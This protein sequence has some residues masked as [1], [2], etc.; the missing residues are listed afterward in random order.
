MFVSNLYL[1]C[2][3]YWLHIVY[4]YDQPSLLF[5]IHVWCAVSDSTSSIDKSYVLNKPCGRV[6]W[7]GDISLM[8]SV[9]ESLCTSWVPMSTQTFGSRI[10][11]SKLCKIIIYWHEFCGMHSLSKWI[12]G[13]HKC[14]PSNRTTQITPHHTPNT[15]HT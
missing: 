9:T 12:Y 15:T 14:V 7:D 10:K 13:L 8:S 4:M 5:C 2:K 6:I 11:K 3:L 1:Y